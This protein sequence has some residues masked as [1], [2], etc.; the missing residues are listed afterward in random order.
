MVR[1]LWQVNISMFKKENPVVL[2][3]NL[4]V[5]KLLARSVIT[6]SK[7]APLLLCTAFQIT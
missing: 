2:H 4:V 5:N 6:E 7:N 3:S 1:D